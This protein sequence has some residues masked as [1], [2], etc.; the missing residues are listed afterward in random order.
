[1]YAILLLKLKPCLGFSR[2]RT[3]VSL[4]FYEGKCRRDRSVRGSLVRKFVASVWP[5]DFV[6]DYLVVCEV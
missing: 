2:A 4:A 5:D 1:M 6:N 3:T